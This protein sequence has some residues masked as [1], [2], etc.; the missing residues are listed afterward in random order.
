MQHFLRSHNGCQFV[1]VLAAACAVLTIASGAQAG[2]SYG[3]RYTVPAAD[4]QGSA[5]SEYTIGIY[6]METGSVL[7]AVDHLENAWRLSRREVAV[8]RRL[9][10][11]YFLLKNFARCE[12][13]LDDIL[14]R[15]PHDY[16]SMLL[17]AKVRYISRDRRGALEML[18]TIRDVHGTEFE[19]E[20][21]L[22]NIAYE[23][24]DVDKALEAYANC[25]RIDPNYAYIQFRYGT[26]LAREMRYQEA[27]QA[28]LTA[29]ELDP[30]FVEPALELAEIYVNSGRPDDAIPVLEKARAADPTSDETLVALAEV[31][32]RTGRLDDGVRILEESRS[33]APLSRDAE[34]LRGRLYYEAGDY[35]EAFGVFKALLDADKDSPEL[36]RILGEISLRM[37]DADQSLHYFDEAIAM[38]PGDYRSYIG[39]FF[40]ASPSFND[41]LVIELSE[42][43]RTELVDKASP[44]VE[45][46]DFEGN[47]LLGISYLSLDYLEKAKRYLLRSNELKGDDRGT[48]LNLASVYE[49][50]EQYENA[51]ECLIKLHELAPDDPSVCNF[52]GYLLAVMGKNLDLAEQLILKA[53][54]GEPENGYY[55]DSLGWVYYQ[56]G[57]YARAVVEL[58]K[59]SM[60]APEDPVILEHLGD[61]YRALR[62]FDEARAAYQKSSELQGDNSE[63]LEKIQSTTQKTGP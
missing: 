52:Y 49:K 7:G 51:E 42:Q 43:E 21:L 23:A 35:K 14:E 54:E 3:N 37:G 18:E 20:R 34:I 5:Y 59:A 12:I 2:R 56:M 24:G 10:E 45:N 57:D 40:A 4:E 13:V 1:L 61:A 32:L 6:L 53:L 9:A 16:D 31:Y 19:I 39:K 46:S 47:Y 22:G 55:L 41:G 63:I 8:G 11:A 48:L 26:L 25:I 17:K 27:E 28:F 30:E 36:A 38:D 50:L 62:R 58:E 29:V 15:I 60:R 44:L 33:R